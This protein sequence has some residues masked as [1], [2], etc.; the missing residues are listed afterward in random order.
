MLQLLSGFN[1]QFPVDCTQL[2]VLSVAPFNVRPPW[3]AVVSVGVLVV[4]N[5]ILGSSIVIVAV[6]TVVVV[7]STVRFPLTVRFPEN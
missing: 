4:P 6:L 7:P 2:I 1:V 3:F 5:S